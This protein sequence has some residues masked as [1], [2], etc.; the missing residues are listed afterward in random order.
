MVEGKDNGGEMRKQYYVQ[1]YEARKNLPSPYMRYSDHETGEEV[2]LR[3]YLKII[4]KRKRIVLTFFISVVITVFVLTLM[5]TPLYKS[6][7]VIKIDKDSPDPIS[8]MGIKGDRDAGY[9]AT[10]Y[11]ILRSETISERVIKK[12]NLDKNKDFLPVQ[13]SLSKIINAVESPVKGAVTYLSS[14][15]ATASSSKATPYVN[16]TYAEKEIP[17]YLI[18]SLIGRLEVLPVKNSQMVQVSFISHKPE[19]SMMVTNAVAEAYIEYDL[20]S[21][22]AATQQAKDFLTKQIEIAKEKL[23][24]SEEKLNDYASKNRIIFFGA[25][26]QGVN[27]KNFSDITS[28]LSAATTER[29]QKE[30]LLRELH[31]SSGTDNP[32]IMNNPLIQELK[33]QQ[34]LLESEYSNLS[35]TFTSDYPKMQS[36]QKQIDSISR[37]IEREKSYTLKSVESDYKASLKKEGAFAKAF[38]TQQKNVLDFQEK[39]AQYATLKREA[40]VNKELHNGLLQ[41]LNEVSVAAMSK[42]TSIQVVDRARYPTYPY[43][44]DTTQNMLLGIVF[45]LVGGIGLAFSVEYFDNTVRDVHDIDK[46]VNIPTLGMIP[47]QEYADSSRGLMI[48]QSKEISAFTEA[49]RSIGV[50]LLSSSAK[51]PKAILVTSAAEKEGKTTVCTSTAVALSESVGNGIIIDADLRRPRL[52]DIFDLDNSAGL[53]TVLSGEVS[54][55]NMDDSIIRPTSINGLSVMTSGPIPLNPSELLLS[56]RIKDLIETLGAKFNFIILDS[57]PLMGMPESVY[58]SKIVDGT[59]LVVKGGGTSKDALTEAARIFHNVDAKILGIVL[60]GAKG[61]DLKYGPYS[62]Y[63]SYFKGQ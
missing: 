2:H 13:S 20:D 9:Y 49:F 11:E 58:L 60:N 22:I 43:K 62:Y 52:H 15:L 32:I 12:L 31:E 51:L 25:E 28:A 53:S 41:K 44:P 38:Q 54:L 18:R 63:S 50:H 6:M 3:D 19:L 4:M 30:A 40:D 57:V 17:P 35:K 45:G 59:I 55:D 10:Q 48:E 61:T 39:A 33:K 47:F 36:L 37:K 24:D 21:R 56:S 46:R 14:I 23:E 5:M 1:Q 8:V 29:M 34:A 7:V 42:S 16:S 27:I 26:K